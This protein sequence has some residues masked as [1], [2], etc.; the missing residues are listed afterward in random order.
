MKIASYN[1]M[2]GGFADYSFAAVKPERLNNIIAA[3]QEINADVIGLIDTF[4]WDKTFST[5]EL[6]NLFGYQHILRTNLDDDRLSTDGGES[7]GLVLMSRKVWT[8]SSTIRL[9]TRNALKVHFDEAI[10][11]LVYLDDLKEAVRL[12]QTEALL[13]SMDDPESTIILG[14]LNTFA[15]A[16]LSAV[17]RDIKNFYNNNPGIEKKFDPV[18]EDMQ[19]GK[20]VQLLEASGFE[21]V[22]AGKGSTIPTKLFPAI[23]DEPF[24]RVDYCFKGENLKVSNFVVHSSKLTGDASDHLP[25]SLDLE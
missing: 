3:V 20:V 19:Q 7:I 1:I 17:S 18:L 25:I 22:G 9:A 4:R 12:K 5:Q 23:A 2:S 21:D 6:R 8:G 16:D 10:I 11:I 14:D 24:L 15:L 13:A